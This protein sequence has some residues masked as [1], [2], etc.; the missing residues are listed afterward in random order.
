MP[1]KPSLIR[2][3]HFHVLRANLLGVIL[4]VFFAR[5]Y[6]AKAISFTP[7][8]S[9]LAGLTAFLIGIAVALKPVLNLKGVFPSKWLLI[10]NLII[11][12]A[13]SL[14]FVR[15]TGAIGVVFCMV[16]SFF[17]SEIGHLIHGRAK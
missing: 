11:A 15:E 5:A 8:I 13:L 6:L 3:Y 2:K 1:G 16:L 7:V 14:L 10:F 12:G 17:L 4:G 9:I